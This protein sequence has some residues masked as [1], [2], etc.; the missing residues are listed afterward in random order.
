MEPGTARIAVDLLGGD[1]APAVVVDGALRAMRADPDLHLLLVGPAEVADELI[2]ELDPAQRV[3]VAVRPVRDVVGMADHP[4][5]ARAESTVRAAVTAVRDGTADALVSAGATGATVTAAV[6]GLGRWPEIRQPALVATLPAVAGPVVLLDVGGSLEP[7]PATLARHAVLGAAYAAV[8]HSISAP[9][10]GLL[11]VGTEA[12]KGDRVR[13]ATDPLLT[14]EPLPAGAR[15]VG[16]VEGYDVTLGARAD[17]VVT[18]GFTGNVLLK[19]IEGAYAMAGG[20][21]A[22]G[23]APRAAALLGVAGTVVVCHG[24]ARAGDVA[25]GIALA[26][27]LWRRRATDLV[28]ALLDGDA[29][30]DRTNRSTDTEVRTS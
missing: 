29:V 5:A 9:R 22:E 30:T 20:P 26:A 14:V 17:V 24:S 15:Y 16:L 13:R 19:A 4:S 21:P 8:A 1:D 10:V 27:H 12:G 3:R 2:A 28:S 25:S 7:R 18:D 11:S 6:L 23:G